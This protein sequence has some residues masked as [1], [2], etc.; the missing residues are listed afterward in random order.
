MVNALSVDLE[1]WL[2]GLASTSRAPAT[3]PRLETRIVPMA[4]RLLGLL[5]QCCVRA[6]F[7]VLGYVAENHPEWILGGPTFSA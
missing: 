1:D 7:F 4:D 6:A 5:E 3:W 2:Q